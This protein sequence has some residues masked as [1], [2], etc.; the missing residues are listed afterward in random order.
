MRRFGTFFCII[1]G[2]GNVAEGL[3]PN[4][5]YEIEQDV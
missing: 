2:F 3:G 4:N 5:V 1:I